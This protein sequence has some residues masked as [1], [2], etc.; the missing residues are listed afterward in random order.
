MRRI[1]VSEIEEL[2]NLSHLW[3]LLYNKEL[4]PKNQILNFFIQEGNKDDQSRVKYFLAIIKIGKELQRV[5]K[6]LKEKSILD[7]E[8]LKDIC[9][10]KNHPLSEDVKLKKGIFLHYIKNPAQVLVW[11]TILEDFTILLTKHLSKFIAQKS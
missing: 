3:T 5:Q 4:P 11:N 1:D 10:F 2:I 6:L 7:L 9:R 8:T